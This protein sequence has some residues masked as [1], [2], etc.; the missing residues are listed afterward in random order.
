MRIA[1]QAGAIV[2]PLFGVIALMATLN[3]SAALLVGG[4]S[5]LV[6]AFAFGAAAL[7]GRH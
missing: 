7:S 1:L 6:A 5:A 4:L 3:V 2:G